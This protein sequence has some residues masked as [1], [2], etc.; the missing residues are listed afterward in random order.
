LYHTQP[1]SAYSTLSLHD[2]LPISELTFSNDSTYK[3]G[4][5][6]FPRRWRSKP[7]GSH[8]L[9]PRLFCRRIHY[10]KCSTF[11][12]E[13]IGNLRGCPMRS[14]EHTTELQSRLD[15]VCRLLLG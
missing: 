4:R 12:S 5:W 10:S 1:P 7:A 14:E 13:V 6:F 3:S 15:L 11:C 9:N 8:E 2:A